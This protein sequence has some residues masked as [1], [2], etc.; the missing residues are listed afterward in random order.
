MKGLNISC[1]RS[2]MGSQFSAAA[3]YSSSEHVFVSRQVVV[4][5]WIFN[6]ISQFGS[7]Y[8]CFGKTVIAKR[9]ASL[10]FSLQRAGKVITN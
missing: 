2:E 7:I 8:L 9:C 1:G 10:Y 6:E 5:S 4:Q 3:N